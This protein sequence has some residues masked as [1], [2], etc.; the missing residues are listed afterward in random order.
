MYGGMGRRGQ[1]GVSL[2]RRDDTAGYDLALTVQAPSRLPTPA[3]SPSR[4]IAPSLP[5]Y[6]DTY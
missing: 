5:V 2:E 6:T 1:S 4:H 3:P